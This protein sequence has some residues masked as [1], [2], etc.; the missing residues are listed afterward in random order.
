MRGS[1]GMVRMLAAVVGVALLGGLAWG[2]VVGTATAPLD[3]RGAREKECSLGNLVADAAR[4]ATDA[5]AALIQA[6]QLRPEVIPAGALT[7]EALT[8]VLLS[9]DERIVL[10]E[11]SG[12]KLLAALERGLSMLRKPSAAFLQISGLTVTFRSDA[13]SEHRIVEVHVG[14]KLLSPEKKYKVAMPSSIAKGAL[15]YFRIFDGLEAKEG[16]AIADA[17]A[18]HVLAVKTVSPTSGRLRDLTP[19]AG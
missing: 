16:P 15:G 12:Q 14:E 7:R 8:N 6:S 5:E 1:K 18:D 11:M 9:P 4:R 3:G 17:V 19:P 10:A 13:P 2:E